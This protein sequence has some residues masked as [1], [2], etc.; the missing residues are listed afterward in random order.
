MLQSKAFTVE[1]ESL[2]RRFAMHVSLWLLVCTLLLKVDFS[3]IRRCV[4]TYGSL[5]A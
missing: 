4:F 3:T 1:K 5:Q 2:L